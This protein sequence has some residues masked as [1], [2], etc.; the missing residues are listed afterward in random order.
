MAVA[1]LGFDPFVDVLPGQLGGY[2]DGVLDGVG[3]GAAVG[4]D[5]DAF[6]AEEG[7]AAVLG[8]VET[9]LEVVESRAGQHV[10]NFPA[11]GG[12]ERFA[13]HLV[14]HVHQ[15]FADFEGDV[16]D[17]SVADDDVGFAGED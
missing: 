1:Q 2:A 15:A 4:N 13:Q 11:D 6:D 12:F 9:F 8:I 10:A 16:A 5:A 17:E 3:V 14:D 7:S